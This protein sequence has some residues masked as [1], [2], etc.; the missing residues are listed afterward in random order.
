[1]KKITMIALAVLT[2]VSAGAQTVYDATNIAQKDLNGK[3]CIRD[4]YYYRYA[5]QSCFVCNHVCGL[6]RAEYV[7]GTDTGLRRF[8]ERYCLFA[9][10]TKITRYVA[11]NHK[12]S[13]E[14]ASA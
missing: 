4:R 10:Q 12:A 2:A 14:R 9:Q 13:V 1:M 3:M 5:V 8:E 7:F 6:H 11:T